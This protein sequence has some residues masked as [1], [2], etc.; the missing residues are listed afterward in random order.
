MTKHILLVA[1][2]VSVLL[3][4]TGVVALAD[5]DPLNP[6]NTQGTFTLDGVEIDFW[7]QGGVP[8]EGLAPAATPEPA[9]LALLGAGALWALSRR[10]AA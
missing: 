1:L 9:T 6:D 8:A 7:K 5:D 4:G 10:R 2:T 3:L